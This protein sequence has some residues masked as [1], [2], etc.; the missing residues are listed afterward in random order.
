[1]TNRTKI[2][3]LV[4]VLAVVAGLWV[5]NVMTNGQLAPARLVVQSNVE[6]TETNLNSQFSGKVKTVTVKEGDPV[7]KG[8][9]LVT[10]ESDTINA[11]LDQANARVAAAKAQLTAATASRDYAQTSY[12]RI[13]GLFEKGLATQADFDDIS[14]KL[15]QALAGMSA[16][17]SQS[18]QAEAGL[19]E[20]KTYLD[21]TT[22]AAPAGGI[23]TMVN[24]EPGELVSTGMPLVVL[25]DLDHPW[26][27][28]SIRETDLSRVSLGQAVAV[29]LPAYQNRV[30]QGKV[31]RINKDADFAV[32]RATNVN[33]EFD[34]VSFGVKV[35]LQNPDKPL[36][37]GMTAFVDFGS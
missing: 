24:V 8:Q 25:T 36:Y 30:F 17:Q 4:V 29:T 27:Q 14:N 10:I 6:M 32:K 1:M 22:I 23:I 26:I 12:N 11:Q 20:V 15:N 31:V 18:A 28:C 3:G 16:V 35:E 19:A 2:I 13:K 37:A 9:T 21:K 34:V 5:A 7:A 33:G